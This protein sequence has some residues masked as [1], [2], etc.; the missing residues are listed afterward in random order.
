[1]G[2]AYAGP[3][4]ALRLT[5]KFVLSQLLGGADSVTQLAT[6]PFVT[7]LR[8]EVRSQIALQLLPMSQHP[9]SSIFPRFV[10]WLSLD[11][12]LPYFEFRDSIKNGLHQI[13]KHSVLL[14]QMADVSSRAERGNGIAIRE[15]GDEPMTDAA[16]AEVDAKLAADIDYARQ[17][18]AKLDAEEARGG[19]RQML[20]PLH[21]LSAS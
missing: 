19:N 8:Q 15:A 2:K 17:L 6:S 7:A 5:G 13:L 20:Y 10:I 21:N 3:R 9:S 11:P 14:L 1:M 12:V 18:Q 16:D 4:E